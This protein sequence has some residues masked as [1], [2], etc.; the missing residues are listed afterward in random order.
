MKTKELMSV[1]SGTVT[2]D[3]AVIRLTDAAFETP[4]TAALLG[5]IA[6]PE[7][8]H[9]LEV[10][11]EMGADHYLM[12]RSSA[13]VRLMEAQVEGLVAGLD[14]SLKDR[15]ATVLVADRESAR[16][17]MG[18]TIGKFSE[19]LGKM[20]SRYV[21][22]EAADALPGIVTRRLD[23]VARGAIVRIDTM[24]QDG[25]QGAL[26][27]HGDRIIKAIREELELVKRQMVESHARAALGVTKGRDFEEELTRVLGGIATGIGA[28]VERCGDHPGVKG[29]KY[30]DHVLTLSG[31]M[32]RGNV[33]R[34][35][36]EAKDHEA[37]NGRFSF[38]A[39]RTA[40][41]QAC[42]NRGAAVAIFI[43]DSAELLPEGRGFGRVDGNFYIAYN[44]EIGDHTALAATIHMAF[45][46]ALLDATAGNGDAVDSEAA[47]REL[48]Q[49]RRLIDEFDAIETAHSGAI[50]SIQKAGTS[51][52]AMRA[53][54]LTAV[55]KL[56]SILSV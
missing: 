33:L 34:L 13:T 17:E 35:V 8:L 27:R 52:S 4:K 47:R 6:E 54:I 23:E 29:R 15:L 51:V 20:L 22:P 18:Q 50:R 43:T 19:D 21:D 55:G 31:P 46:Q 56:D 48:D 25:D 37:S 53:A 49:L 9:T 16:S 39:V 42:D 32:S 11:L 28:E 10:I 14:Q 40:C 44:P 41:R 12:A 24:L 30:G 45:T 7:R 26:A 1:A 3:G 36:V 38:E 5:P 2:V